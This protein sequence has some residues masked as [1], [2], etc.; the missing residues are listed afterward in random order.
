MLLS[1]RLNCYYMQ[2]KE[3]VTAALCHE[4]AD[5]VPLFDFLYNKI[6]LRKILR[7]KH[8]RISPEMYMKAQLSLGFDIVCLF[9]DEPECSR[10]EWLSE[11]TFVNEWGIRNKVIDRMG[12]YLDGSIKTRE[13]LEDF[14]PPDPYAKGRSRTIRTILKNYGELIACAPAI[15]GPFTH[16]WSMTGFDVF[17]KAMYRYPSFIHR[18]LGIVNRYFIQLGKMVID[19]GAEFIWIA[20]DFGDVHGPMITPECFR[21]FILP[22]FRE[23]VNAFRKKGVWVLL[24][25]DGNVMPIMKD[26]VDAGIDAFHPVERKAEMD[27]GGIKEVYGDRITV[28]GNVEASNLIPQGSYEKIDKQIRECFDIAAPG[29]GYIFASDHSIHPGISAERAEFL[30]QSAKKYRFYARKVLPR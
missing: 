25:C 16:A 23:Q 13:D 4:E 14:C 17:V 21:R 11:D 26:L 27:L 30:F 12:W 19:E 10:L 22:Y 28:V 29:G 18:L 3:R 6:S 8:K 1:G 24:H 15:G 9:F 2:A 5:A 20:D 7:E